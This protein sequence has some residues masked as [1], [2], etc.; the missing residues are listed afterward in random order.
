M[1]LQYSIPVLALFVL[2]IS[3]TLYRVHVVLVPVPM[4][5]VGNK[6]EQINEMTRSFAK[7]LEG[8]VKKYPEQ[9]FNFYNFW[10]DEDV[11]CA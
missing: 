6:R 7:I 1:A 4:P 3:A 9:W 10:K 5:E 11:S 8:I 2:K